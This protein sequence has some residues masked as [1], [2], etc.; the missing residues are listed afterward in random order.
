MGEQ[1]I[2]LQNP[3]LTTILPENY[4]IIPKMFEPF[5]KPNPLVVE[6]VHVSNLKKWKTKLLIFM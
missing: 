6:D 3:K 2:Q 1:I 4:N 5:E